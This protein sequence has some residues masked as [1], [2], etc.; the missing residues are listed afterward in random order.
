[1]PLPSEWLVRGWRT[2][3]GVHNYEPRHLEQAVEFLTDSQ[4]D[5]DTV[6]SAPIALDDVP[7]EVEAAPGTFL[8]AAVKV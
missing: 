5:W 3:T 1:M 2:I 4:I 8:R 6:V 7:A